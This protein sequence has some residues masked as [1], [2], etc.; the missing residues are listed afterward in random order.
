MY[1]HLLLLVSVVFP[2]PSHQPGIFGGLIELVEKIE[3]EKSLGLFITVRLFTR[4]KEAG[5]RTI[6]VQRDRYKRLEFVDH[7]G[8]KDFVASM[9]QT[10]GGFNDARTGVP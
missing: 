10:I 3:F 4:T 9:R 6:I 7:V 8:I 1:S 5:F 2:D